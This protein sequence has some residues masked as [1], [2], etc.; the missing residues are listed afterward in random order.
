MVCKS[1]PQTFIDQV[2]RK[3]FC[4]NKYIQA[5]GQPGIKERGKYTI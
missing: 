5:C 2:Y 4:G 3:L 1:R